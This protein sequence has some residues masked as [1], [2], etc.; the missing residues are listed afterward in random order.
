MPR[1]TSQT[2]RD[3]SADRQTARCYGY[4]WDREDATRKQVSPPHAA[5]VAAVVSEQIVRGRRGIDVGCGSG[6][7]VEIMARTNPEVYLVALDLSESV[8]I[9]RRRCAGLLNVG[10]VQASALALPFKDECFDFAY[11]FGVLHHTPA[12]WAGAKE[13]G[14]VLADGG[15][16]YLYLYEDHADHPV[17]YWSLKFITL[18]RRGARRL[19]RRVLYGLCIFAAPW[20]YLCFTIPAKLASRVRGL[21]GWALAWPFNFLR[22][23]F[24]GIG[25]MFDRFGAPIEWRYS[26][27]EARALLVESGLR[28]VQTRRIAGIAGWVVWGMKRLAR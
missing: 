1:P 10:V 28:H 2:S 20:V 5:Q 26:E 21:Q 9:T 24:D 23:P 6:Y 27:A 17:K 8:K 4:L 7:D 13:I 25:D 11:S 14:R 15:A 22:G 3:D 12:P 16:A 19:H 18:L